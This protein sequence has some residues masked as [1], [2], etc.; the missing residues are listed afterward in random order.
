MNAVTG[1]SRIVVTS[2]PSALWRCWLGGRKGNRP[3]KNLSGGVLA[4][5]TG[6]LICLERGADLHMT[7]L[8]PLPSHEERVTCHSVYQNQAGTD[9]ILYPCRRPHHGGTLQAYKDAWKE[10]TSQLESVALYVNRTS[11]FCIL[12]P[13]LPPSKHDVHRRNL[14]MG[15]APCLILIHRFPLYIM[16]PYSCTIST[17]TGSAARDDAYDVMLG[18]GLHHNAEL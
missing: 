14:P 4:W 13:Q 3:V 16:C 17:Y 8:M 10:T 1:Y 5:L 11:K 9:R 12:W 18:L 2:A 7:Q 6:Y 15:P